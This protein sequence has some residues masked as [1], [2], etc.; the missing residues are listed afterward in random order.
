MSELSALFPDLLVGQIGLEKGAVRLPKIAKALL[1]L[2]P[3]RNLVPKPG[4]SPC[5]PV[6]KLLLI[7]NATI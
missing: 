2:V 3:L 1:A 4:T 5:R 6:F 7:T